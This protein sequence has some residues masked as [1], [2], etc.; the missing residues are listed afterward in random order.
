MEASLLKMVPITSKCQLVIKEI[1]NM[2][3]KNLCRP[4]DK[5]VMYC[6]INDFQVYFVRTVTVCNLLL[7]PDAKS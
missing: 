4:R 7:P 3:K 6:L 1:E 5:T 2:G